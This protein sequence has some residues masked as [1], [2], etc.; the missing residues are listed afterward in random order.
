MRS[1]TAFLVSSILFVPVTMAEDM[2]PTLGK[3]GKELLIEKFEGNDIPKGWT[4]NVG[5]MKIQDGAL[6]ISELASD[7]H[8]GAFRKALPIQDMAIQID[9]MLDGAKTFNVGFDPVAGELK[10]KGH[11]YSVVINS[12]RWSISESNDKANPESK[13][14]LHAKGTIQLNPGKWYTLMIENKGENV[15]A[16]IAGQ[17]ALKA[18]ANDFKVKKPGL[19]VR[20]GGPDTAGVL[21]DNI[22]VFELE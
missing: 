19:I 7:K 16:T 22:Q 15:V 17:G 18:K 14:I 12:D 2:S 9:F 10:K 21:I 3:K 11:L 13:A 4:K 20:A 8:V 6:R 5:M 1:L